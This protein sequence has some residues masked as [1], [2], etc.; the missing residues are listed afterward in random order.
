M[1]F[2]PKW[3]ALV[4]L[5]LA[6]PSFSQVSLSGKVISAEDSTAIPKAQINLN[7]GKTFVANEKGYFEIEGLRKDKDYTLTVFKMNYDF[8]ETTVKLRRNKSITLKL[9][10]LSEQL[11]EVVLTRK[12]EKLFAHQRLK[13]VEGTAIYAGKKT[14]VVNMSKVTGNLAANNA[15]QIY[16]Q[17]VGLNIYEN[18]DAG[19]QL[20][21][22]GRGLN[23]NR[24]KNFNT[25]Q[26]GY[27]IA[28]DV[29]GYPESYYTPPPEALERVEV[30][31]GAASLQ[32]GTQFGG[33]I[34]FI[35]KKPNP[36]KKFELVSRQTLGSNNLFTSFNSVS[37]TVGEISYYG[38]YNYKKGDGFRPNSDFESNTAFMHLGWQA[39]ENTKLEFEYTFLDYLSQQPGGLTDAQFY[40]DPDFSNR[41]RNYFDVSWNLFSAKLKQKL[42]DRTKFKL[43]LYG[44]DASRKNIGFRDNRVSSV[45]PGGPRELIVGDFEN[46][47]A[48]ARLLSEYDLGDNTS[49]FLIGSKYYN[50]NNSQRQ[51][52][53]SASSVADFD[54]ADGQFPNYPRQ[55][56]FDFPNENLAF[57]SENLF[58]VTDKFSLTPGVRFEYI[59]TQSEGTYKNIILDLA[60]NPLLNETLSDNRKFERSFVLLGLGSS[61]KFSKDAELYAN[62]SQNYRSV[63]FNDIRVTNPVFQVDPNITDEEG[64]TADLGLRGRV[65]NDL[66]TY[67]VNVFGLRYRQRIGEILKPEERV[68]AQG[69]L[70]ETGRIIRFRGNIGDSFVYGLET[71]GNLNLRKVIAP[72]AYDYKANVFFNGSFTDS[73]YTDSDQNNVEGNEVEF[74]PKINLKTGINFGYKNLLGSLQYTYLSK[75]FTDATNAPQDKSESQRGIEGAIPAY[76]ILDLSFSYKYKFLKLETGIN[77]ILD[78]RYFTRRATGYPGP[79]IIPAKPLTWYTTLQVK[80]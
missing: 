67:D 79:G 61:Y 16:S 68:N 72:T 27:D 52:P 59:K 43:T 74:I 18:S 62:F 48:E 39:S 40:K 44:L 53:G 71:F 12:R 56:N 38:F 80:L 15:R 9:S 26:N 10:P 32:Y 8:I 37:G 54:F 7:N 63:T 75:Q 69:D 73:E 60:G 13:D 14:E 57:F 11:S 5:L 29:L 23:P 21:I 49:Y 31:R 4:L 77:N 76:G 50:S 22:G 17:I 20:N 46:Y 24:T 41:S 51:G 70:E 34:N 3:I 33:L 42:S 6:Q 19:L 66:L 47:A 45:D 64:F 30:I 25:R 55:S 35:T 28:A 1:E 2:K 65:N 78:N 58:Q 36:D